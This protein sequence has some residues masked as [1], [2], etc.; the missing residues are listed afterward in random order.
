RHETS[1]ERPCPQEV[2]GAEDPC[3]GDKGCADGSSKRLAK[4][5][6]TQICDG[7]GHSMT[8][9]YD[10][11]VDAGY[12]RLRKGVRV[13]RTERLDDSRLI[14]YDDAGDPIGIELLNV[15]ARG[16]TPGIFLTELRSS[17]S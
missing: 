5:G 4:Q 6:W 14:D 8:F 9:E 16:S 7:V 15:K 13:A 11:E 17:D 1:P 3:R 10:K 12:I 2:P